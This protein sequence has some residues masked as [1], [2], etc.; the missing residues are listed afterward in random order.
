[1]RLLAINRSTAI[2]TCAALAD[3]ALIGVATFLATVLLG[4]WA[5]PEELGLFS[6]L[7]PAVF[8]AIALQESLIT[9]PYTCY[10]ARHAAAD[11]RRDYLGS[12]LAHSWILS[13]VTAVI[14]G[15]ASIVAYGAGGRS[16]VTAT[17]VL[18]LVIPGVLL[19]EFARRV[20]YADLRPSAAVWVSGG[21]SAVQLTLM[22]ALHASGR[23]N[24]A[25]AF[26]AM[27]LS[28]A[29]GGGMWLY[30]NRSSVNFRSTSLRSAF[31][32]NWFMGRWTAASQLGEV[33]R[34]QMFPWLLALA[35]DGRSVGIYAAC[36]A[37]AA[38]SA[39]LQMALSNMLLP[40]FAATEERGGIAAANRLMWQATGWV[41]LALAVWTLAFIAASAVVVPALYGPEYIGTQWPLVLLLLAQL[42][43]AASMPAAR[44]IVALDRPHL[45]FISQ[46]AGIA[47]NFVF[48]I[49]LVLWAG[50]TG[51]A[52]AAL[53]ATSVKAILSAAFYG[54][55]L[56]RRTLEDLESR[57]AESTGFKASPNVALRGARR[58][59][60]VAGASASWREEPS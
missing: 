16:Y 17:A 25:T 8:A 29:V 45:D 44:A 20:V 1:M 28:S 46:M 49:P 6:L 11:E 35:V 13:A 43:G 39:P 32:R 33:V 52:A 30:L 36:A 57:I 26:A 23:L 60:A 21:V 58:R 42:V 24:A 10:A 14:A 15:V 56:R 41:S 51:A 4:R 19:R 9:A 55:E 18:A 7:F 40:Q 53:L 48:G 5:G 2:L 3:R 22:A 59:P 38:L 37:V 47:V 54:R 50:I 27:G 31:A 34:V 12:V